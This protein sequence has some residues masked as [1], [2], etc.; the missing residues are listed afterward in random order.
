MTCFSK[1]NHFRRANYLNKLKKNFYV[2]FILCIVWF[3]YHLF[4]VG[5]SYSTFPVGRIIYL[6]LYIPLSDDVCH[7]VSFSLHFC[8]I[9]NN[10]SILLPFNPL[11]VGL[12]PSPHH[13]TALRSLIIFISY[14]L[15]VACGTVCSY[16]LDKKKR[17]SH[18]FR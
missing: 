8:S 2:A 16:L 10:F 15:C 4:K 17:Q 13:W 18:K 5:F 14:R 12:D 11:Q 6:I 9:W 7:L 3:L 1:M